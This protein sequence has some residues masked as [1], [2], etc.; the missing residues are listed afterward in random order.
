MPKISLTASA[1]L[2]ASPGADSVVVVTDYVFQFA[3][4][5]SQTVKFQSGS[6]DLTGAM[7]QSQTGPY[8]PR[9]HFQT[10]PGEDFKIAVANTT[11]VAG[12][13]NYEIRTAPIVH[14]TRGSKRKP[15]G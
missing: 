13:F 11:P 15:R 2:V 6:T 14:A 12:H 1:T 9:G 5:A 8:T 10:A 7:P 4:G 3:S